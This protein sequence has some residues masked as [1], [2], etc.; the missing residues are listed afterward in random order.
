MKSPIRLRQWDDSACE[1]ACTVQL[2]YVAGIINEWEV[3]TLVHTI[4]RQIR[5]QPGQP[6]VIAG[7]LRLLLEW[8]FGLR[9][10]SL[11]SYEKALAEGGLEYT[12]WA[13]RQDGF[14]QEHIQYLPHIFPALQQRA[15]LGLELRS[16]YSQQ[17]TWDERQATSEDLR[18]HLRQ[19][20]VVQCSLPVL[21]AGIVHVVL[22]FPGT[23][24]S[25]RVYDPEYGLTERVS[26]RN[27]TKQMYPTLTAYQLP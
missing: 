24:Q 11:A 12:Q 7:N 1:T 9:T 10:I 3:L 21:E 23:M 20:H 13:C 2:L 18:W 5:R 22:V 8:G 16:A 27:L 26:I 6:D 17:W 14:S 25:C 15:K 4:D 19:N